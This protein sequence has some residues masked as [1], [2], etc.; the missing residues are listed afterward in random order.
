MLEGMGDLAAGRPF[1]PSSFL[2]VLCWYE[3]CRGGAD[4]GGVVADGAAA[5][6]AA[7]DDRAAAK[8]KAANILAGRKYRRRLAAARA[9]ELAAARH[10]AELATQAG[11]PREP[12]PRA[13]CVARRHS[14]PARRYL[15][16][17]QCHA[18]PSG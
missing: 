13:Q 15:P 11:L 7:A 6:G 8:R 3:E 18:R 2:T 17:V 10:A 4:R 1:R 16:P 9:G 14:P 12:H 5:D